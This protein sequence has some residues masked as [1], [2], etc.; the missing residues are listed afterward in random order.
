MLFTY[1]A[2]LKPNMVH[3]YKQ[4]VVVSACEP[5]V[6][7][8]RCHGSMEVMTLRHLCGPV[9]GRPWNQF[10]GLINTRPWS[11]YGVIAKELHPVVCKDGAH[12][13]TAEKMSTYPAAEGASCWLAG[14]G[15]MA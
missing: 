13:P 15:V 2:P 7:A 12:D 8:A 1:K 9:E 10:S 6:I 3:I 14:Q 4:A 11:Y 5:C